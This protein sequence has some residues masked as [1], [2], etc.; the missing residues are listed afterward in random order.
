MRTIK[1]KKTGLNIYYAFR[2]WLHPLY[3][4]NGFRKTFFT[5]LSLPCAFTLV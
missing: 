4:L 5:Y 2:A 1:I 3:L